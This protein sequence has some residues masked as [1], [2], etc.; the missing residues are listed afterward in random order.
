MNHA[1]KLV[2]IGCFCIGTNQVDLDHARSLGIPVFNSPYANSRSVAELIISQLITLSRQLGDRNM[3][4]HQGNWNKVSS[5]CR[6]I[7]GKKLGI[8]GY[9]HIGRQVSCYIKALAM[10]IYTITQAQAIQDRVY[11]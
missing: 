4:M 10:C 6:E 11:I 5:G 2:A 1:K 8:V 9:G 3:E 7:R